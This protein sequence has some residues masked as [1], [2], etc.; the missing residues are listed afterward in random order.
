MKRLLKNVK[1]EL[2]SVKNVSNQNSK[3]IK[4]NMIGQW[5]RKNTKK[6]R[7]KLKRLNLSK[8]IALLNQK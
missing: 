6:C 5:Y 7:L 3:I 1:E 2:K 4:K 8:K